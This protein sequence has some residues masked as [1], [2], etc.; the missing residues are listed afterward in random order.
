MGVNPAHIRTSPPRSSSNQWWSLSGSQETDPLFSITVPANTIIDIVADLRLV[1]SLK[2][3]PQ[4]MSPLAPFWASCMVT[5]FLSGF[6]FLI[7]D[8]DVIQD[9]CRSW[10]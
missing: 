3:P 6:V 10:H 1:E 9:F 4:E 8:P 5:A 2:L 7:S